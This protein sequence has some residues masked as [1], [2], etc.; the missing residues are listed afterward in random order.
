MTPFSRV[1]LVAKY[2]HDRAVGEAARQLAAQL[3]ADGAR[4]EIETGLARLSRMEAGRDGVAATLPLA[5]IGGDALAAVIGGDG[6]FIRVAREL[7]PRGVSLVGVN[8]GYLGFL[9]DIPLA[10]MIPTVR[11]VARGRHNPESRMMLEV[12]VVR[13]GRQIVS[14]CAIND[15]VVSR[16]EAGVLLNMEILVGRAYALSMRADGLIVSTPTGSTAYA[17]SAGGP[18]IEPALDSVL[19]APLAPHSLT[20]RPIALAPEK[21]VAVKLTKARRARLHIDGQEDIKLKEGDCVTARRHPKRM[22]VC[23]PRNYDYF[24]TLRRKLG[25]GG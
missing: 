25:W 5:E 24:E 7:A 21:P 2:K 23:H 17:M 16:G 1:A 3:A 10:R 22:R 14:T 15:I 18:I 6:T 19:L 4:V 11:E 12:R 9:T 13:D 8:L 20:Q